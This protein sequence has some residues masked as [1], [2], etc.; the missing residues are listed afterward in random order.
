MH[1]AGSSQPETTAGVGAGTEMLWGEEREAPGGG[2]HT[3]L[4]LPLVNTRNP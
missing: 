2:V 3:F 4:L 1:H